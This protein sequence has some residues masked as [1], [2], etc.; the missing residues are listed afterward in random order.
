MAEFGFTTLP[1]PLALT[2]PV[3]DWRSTGVLRTAASGKPP[4]CA[5]SQITSAAVPCPG[6]DLRN[7]HLNQA[8]YALFLF[9][10]D[11]CNG[12]LVSW[13]DKRLAAADQAGAADRATSMRQS[14]LEPLGCIYGVSSKVLSMA[15]SELLL[16]ADPN[17]ER[18][19]TTGASMVAVDT[20][21]HNWLHRTG[22]LARRGAAHA[23][24]PACYRPGGC[25]NLIEEAARQ[26]DARQFCPD[27][28][29]FFPRLLQ[30]G[31]LDVLRQ[32]RPRHLQRQ[33]DRR[34]R[35]LRATGVPA[36]PGMPAPASA[37]AE[38]MKPQRAALQ[39]KLSQRI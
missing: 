9:I 31:D 4:I 1:M 26:I 12:D 20:L 36:V 8:A 6:H 16:G 21:V 3:P 24:G 13:I 11:V 25:A 15:L 7:G 22:A 2:R 38:Q 28:P 39:T 23:Y 29:A 30:K 14:L 37:V 17:R 27:G 34:P 10:R 32:S 18:W 5:P 19:V 33:P 35:T